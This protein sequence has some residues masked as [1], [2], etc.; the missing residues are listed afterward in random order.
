MGPANSPVATEERKACDGGLELRVG[1]KNR[2]Y[3]S[4]FGQR[5]IE[6][7]GLGTTFADHGLGCVL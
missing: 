3:S 4:V 2:V 7:K 1:A 6:F 5:E